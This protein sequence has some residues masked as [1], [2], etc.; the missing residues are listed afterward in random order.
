MGLDYKS[1]GGSELCSTNPCITNSPFNVESCCRLEGW[2]WWGWLLLALGIC[3]CCTLCCC[4]ACL[5]PLLGGGNKRRRG[6][7]RGQDD[8]GSWS[9]SHGQSWSSSSGDR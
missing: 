4:P 1:R 3:Y 9:S 6:G 8:S 7:S 2:P 5:S